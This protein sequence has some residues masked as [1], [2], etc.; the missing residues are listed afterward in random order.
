[1]IYWFGWATKPHPQKTADFVICLTFALVDGR[2]GSVLFFLGM[3]QN[4]SKSDTI[5]CPLCMR[6][7]AHMST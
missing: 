1:M 4:V 5:F 2:L 7:Q 3:D 6:L